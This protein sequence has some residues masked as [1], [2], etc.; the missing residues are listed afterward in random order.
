MA[1]QGRTRQTR[2]ARPSTQVG[3]D[4]PVS[5]GQVAELAAQVNPMTLLQGLVQMVSQGQTPQTQTPTRARRGVQQPAQPQTNMNTNSNQAGQFAQSAPQD[6]RSIAAQIAGKVGEQAIK[7]KYEE[8]LQTGQITPEQLLT[9]ANGQQGVR[10]TGAIPKS[11]RDVSITPVS[12]PQQQPQQQAQGILAQLFGGLTGGRGIRLGSSADYVNLAQEQLLKQ[13]AENLRFAREEGL[14]AAEKEQNQATLTKEVLKETQK[15]LNEGFLEPNQIFTKFEKAS[16]PFINIRDSFSK[17]RNAFT[18]LQTGE[19]DFINSNPVADL[20]LL[21]NTAK[22]LD[23]GGRVTDSDVAIQEA[24]AGKYGDKIQKIVRKF[25]K[26]GGSFLPEERRLFFNAAMKRFQAQEKEQAKTT[27][28]FEAL[29]R[30]NNINP[31]NIIRDVGLASNEIQEFSQEE[32][33]AEAR[34]RG[35][36]I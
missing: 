8:G 26:R 30:R 32:L 16:E 34:R 21:F 19:L 11:G 28:Q 27:K 3:V 1:R 31:A 33:I 29:A 15:Q 7:K 24:T 22:T 36:N 13:Q 12:Q 25:Q 2:V 17:I 4:A 18:N 6:P 9:L 10:D 20:D 35:L 14:T 23:P 5:A